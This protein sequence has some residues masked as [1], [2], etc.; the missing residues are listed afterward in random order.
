MPRSKTS[1]K[2]INECKD[3]CK[4]QQFARCAHTEGRDLRLGG[5]VFGDVVEVVGCSG[6]VGEYAH[7]RRHLQAEQWWGRD[8]GWRMH[9]PGDISRQRGK[10][11][12]KEWRQEGMKQQSKHCIYAS[13]GI[14]IRGPAWHSCA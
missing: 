14:Y 8:G 11:I 12:W 6:G 5:Q 3:I 13:R 9:I 4:T 7:T 10:G 1:S 2:T